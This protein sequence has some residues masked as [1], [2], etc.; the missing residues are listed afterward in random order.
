MLLV[1]SGRSVLSGLSG[2]FEVVGLRAVLLRGG[3]GGTMSTSVLHWALL[4][5]AAPAL[6]IVVGG[7]LVI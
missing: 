5:A 1:L 6:W 3:A 2:L 4:L 7:V